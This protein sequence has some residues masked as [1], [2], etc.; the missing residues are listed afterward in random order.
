MEAPQKKKDSTERWSDSPFG[1]GI[2]VRNGKT[3]GKN[4]WD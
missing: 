4:I 3:L 1:P 2:Y